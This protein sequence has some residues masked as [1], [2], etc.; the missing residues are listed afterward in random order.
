MKVLIAN[1]G[2]IAIRIMRTCRELGFTTVAVYS[3]ADQNSLHTRYADEAINIGPARASQ[4]YLNIPALLEA[5]TQIKAD[6]VH[7]GYGFLSE[8]PQFGRAVEDAGMTF[9]GP[10]PE[11][12]AVFGD[13]ITARKAA[14]EAGLT[15]LPGPDQPLPETRIGQH[16]PPELSYPV[17]VKA[18]AGGGGKGIRL[19]RSEQE[20]QEVVNLAREE[21]KAAFGDGSIYLEPLVKKARHIE[22][23]ILGDGRGHVLAFGER[24][25]SIQRRHQKLI[26]EAP[27]PTISASERDCIIQAAKALGQIT[28]YRSLGTVEFLMDEEGQ[29]FFIEVNPRIQVEHPV[30]EMVTGVDLVREQLL[31]ATTGAL[32][33]K[34]EDIE[35]RGAAI[36]ARILAEDPDVD[37]LPTSGEISYL[38]EPGGPGIRIDSCLYQGM[39][40]SADYDSLV[41]KIIAWG[42][43]RRTAIHRLR[44]GIKEYQIGGLKTDLAFLTKILESHPYQAGKITTT[45]LDDYRIELEMPA[46]STTRDAAIAA[47]LHIHNQQSELKNHQAP[48]VSPWRQAAWREQTGQRA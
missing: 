44:R 17:L 7:P 42:P 2:E 4:S 16:I 47:A 5:A 13:K 45:F 20:L 28:A 30:T 18:A 29:F 9:I 24:E 14:R 12:M 35:L 37:F 8:N 1:R 15:V 39:K 46:E 6:A 10:R 26:E 32:G 19:A 38:K 27:A 23:Q 40:V 25:C 48:K 22:V 3:D 34:Q 36:E 33:I 31:L 43:D 21:A 11:T 41:A